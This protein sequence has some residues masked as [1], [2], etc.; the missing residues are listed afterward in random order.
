MF[1]NTANGYCVEWENNRNSNISNM[2]Y[3]GVNFLRIHIEYFDYSRNITI[4]VIAT[5]NIDEKNG[6]PN[7]VMSGN[8]LMELLYDLGVDVRDT[9]NISKDPE[10]FLINVIKITSDL[11]YWNKQLKNFLASQPT[12]K[13]TKYNTM[14][15][16]Y[17]STYKAAPS[18]YQEKR[19]FYNEP[20][21][22]GEKEKIKSLSAQIEEK[23]IKIK[24][25]EDELQELKEEIKMIKAINQEC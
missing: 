15:L 9:K 24:D 13:K 22:S 11:N 5:D 8:F 23:D 18:N 16:N 12:R 17:P 3:D 21:M 2:F 25:L 6:C 1:Y 7:V 10:R 4:K 14:P 20:L 19:Y